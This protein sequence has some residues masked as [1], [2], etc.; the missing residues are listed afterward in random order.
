[1]HQPVDP[2]AYM[3]EVPRFVGFACF[4]PAEEGG[5][6]LISDQA[7]I[8]QGLPAAMLERLKSQGV[9]YLR[10][11]GDADLTPNFTYP[12]GSWQKRFETNSFAEAQRVARSDRQLG[13]GG[14]SLELQADLT[15]RLRWHSPAVATAEGGEER[16]V[17]SILDYHNSSGVAVEGAMGTSAIHAMWGD[18]AEFSPGEVAALQK[19]ARSSV[20]ASVKLQA[21]DVILLDNFRFGHGREAYH[22]A[23]KHAALMSEEVPRTVRVAHCEE[24]TCHARAG[25]A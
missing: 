4:R 9:T 16:L 25:R 24:D 15:V 14:A 18:G 7:K 10:R 22:G 5:E 11:Y 20:A 21:G 12:T 8:A 6:L 13:A 23:R 19:A 17:Q 3:V 1:M 2:M